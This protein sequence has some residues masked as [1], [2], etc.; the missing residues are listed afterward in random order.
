MSDDGFADAGLFAERRVGFTPELHVLTEG[1]A[2]NESHPQS[3]LDCSHYQSPL[4]SLEPN[5]LLGI[6]Q[7]IRNRLHP[8]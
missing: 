6:S 8:Q 5:D 7:C 1:F 4:D 3:P 2:A